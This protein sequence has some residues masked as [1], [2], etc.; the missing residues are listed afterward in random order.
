MVHSIFNIN[1]SINN[2]IDKTRSKSKDPESN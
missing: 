2:S 1:E